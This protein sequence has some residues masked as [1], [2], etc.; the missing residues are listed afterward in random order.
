MLKLTNPFLPH[1]TKPRS[2]VLVTHSCSFGAV[3]LPKVT[4]L[5]PVCMFELARVVLFE[6]DCCLLVVMSAICARRW[7]FLDTS[8]GSL[9]ICS[10]DWED[11]RWHML[12]SGMAI[13]LSPSHPLTLSPS[14]P[15]SCGMMMQ[16][17]IVLNVGNKIKLRI[18]MKYAHL[19]SWL[20]RNLCFTQNYVCIYVHAHLYVCT[21]MGF[22][23]E[24]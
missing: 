14:H 8:D 10:A 7:L 5:R 18:V 20:Q 13:S 17:C 15:L 1:P 9:R 4:P 22:T 12:V 2:A 23:S 24:S 19:V 21:F 16:W 3:V 6:K 11:L